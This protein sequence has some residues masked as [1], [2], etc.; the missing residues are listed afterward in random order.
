MEEAK[1][2][3]RYEVS[4]REPTSQPKSKTEQVMRGLKPKS[5]SPRMRWTEYIKVILMRKLRLDQNQALHVMEY[6]LFQKS[7]TLRDKSKSKGV[8]K[9]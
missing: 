2:D 5:K 1:I 8:N 9:I 4:K 6:Y 7:E 3:D